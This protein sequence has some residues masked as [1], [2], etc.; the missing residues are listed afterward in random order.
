MKRISL[1]HHL[2][3]LAAIVLTVM[4]ALSLQAQKATLSG[5][6]RGVPD[7][8]S[9]V[10]SKIVNNRPV[11][12]DTIRLDNK[13]SFKVKLENAAPTLY[14]L[15]T[16]QKDGGMCH[17]LLEPKDKVKVDL[18]YF[19]DRRAFSIASCSGSRNVELY[20]QFNDLLLAA[21]TPEQ[22]SQL[23]DRAAQLLSNNSNILM[24][25]FLVTFFERN[26]DSYVNLFAKVRDGLINEYPDA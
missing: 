13:G 7:G 8:S 6:L 26:F 15:Q 14:L 9:I 4:T 3:Q 25:A 21:I 19:A 22:Q 23:P 12:V 5:S 1:I 11:P 24:S 10:L 18:V 17:L 20:R 16:T 2:R